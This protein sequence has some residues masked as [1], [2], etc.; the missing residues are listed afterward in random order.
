MICLYV[1]DE[2]PA[3]GRRAAARWR[4]A[5]VAGAIAARPA[6]EPRR[7]RRRR[8]CCARALRQRSSPSLRAKPAPMA[9]SGTR[10]RKRRIG[11]SQSDV[12]TALRGDWRHLAQ[13]CRRSSGG[14]CRHPQPRKA[15]ACGYSRRSGGGCRRRAI[16]QN[17]CP[18]R[19][20]YA[21]DRS[22]PAK[23]SKA[24]VS[25]RRIRTGPAV[26]GKPGRRAN[27]R[28]KNGWS[29]FLKAASPAMPTIATGP[30]A[31]AHPVS[32]RICASAKSARARSGTP[33]TLPPPSALLSPATS[34]N[35]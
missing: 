9:C 33:R 6:E 3:L 22:L 19:S 21:P 7:D 8:S 29:D 26:C 14:P 35:S 5:L 2:Q 24:G 12:A 28:R 1:F 4:G 32:R 34:T 13:L 16:R 17:L 20:L 30:T 10:S 15:G 23:P 18:L 31:T 11:P 27:S 25:S